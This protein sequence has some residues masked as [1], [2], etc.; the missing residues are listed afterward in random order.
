MKKPETRPLTDRVDDLKN[1]N[2]PNTA[3]G[4]RRFLGMIKFYHRAVLFPRL[5]NTKP[6]YTLHCRHFEVTNLWIGFLRLRRPI[7]LASCKDQLA[8]ATLLVHPDHDAQFALFCDASA[9][10]FGDVAQQRV[11]GK[12][13]EP[14]AFFQN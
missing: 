6:P 11:H 14:L 9:S 12:S 2:R 3:K 5:L 1:F 4:L 10:S 13:L 7:S 8:N